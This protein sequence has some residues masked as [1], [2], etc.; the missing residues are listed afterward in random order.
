[1]LIVLQVMHLKRNF[2][3]VSDYAG[4]ATEELKDYEM[5]FSEWYNSII[6]CKTSQT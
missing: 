6:E 3:L 2:V 1:M 5:K 4:S